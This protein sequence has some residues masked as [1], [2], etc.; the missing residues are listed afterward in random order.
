VFLAMAAWL[1]ANRAAFD[2]Q[3]WCDCAGQQ[4][5]VILPASAEEE[6]EVSGRR[7]PG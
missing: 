7:G 4:M 2:L 3:D 1:R 5:T 6:Y